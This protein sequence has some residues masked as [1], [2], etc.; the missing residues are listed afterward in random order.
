MSIEHIV[1]IIV[2]WFV[3]SVVVSLAVGRFFER[4]HIETPD[5]ARK[6]GL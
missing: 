1:W 6:A 3:V 2:G 4:Q 5:R